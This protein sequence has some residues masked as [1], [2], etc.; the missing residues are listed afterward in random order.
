MRLLFTVAKDGL[1]GAIP[2]Q[3]GDVVSVDPGDAKPVVL[4]R[5]LPADYRAL[6]AAEAAG[7]L[8]RAP[9]SPVPEA[10]PPV[11]PRVLAFPPAGRRGAVPPERAG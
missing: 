10:A 6:Y 11:A 9:V 5:P 8:T 3:A 2:V 7:L 1:L 4:V